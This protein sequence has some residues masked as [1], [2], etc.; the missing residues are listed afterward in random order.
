MEDSGMAGIESPVQLVVVDERGAYE[1]GIAAVAEWRSGGNDVKR[2]EVLR[3]ATIRFRDKLQ[4]IDPAIRGGLL[5]AF[6][7]GWQSATQTRIEAEDVMTDG[8]GSRR[9]YFLGAPRSGVW[10]KLKG[11]FTR[12]NG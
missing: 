10:S 12:S 8:G 4:R 5:D 9:E 2:F 6:A 1:A 11:W 3:W 7:R